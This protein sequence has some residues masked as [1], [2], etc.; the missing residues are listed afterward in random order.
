MNIRLVSD[1]HLEKTNQVVEKIEAAIPVLEKEVDTVLILAGDICSEKEFPIL[2][3]CIKGR[4]KKVIYIMGNH[5]FFNDHLNREENPFQ[6]KIKELNL[7]DDI[8][9]LEDEH[10][11]IDGYLFWGGT[12]WLNYNNGDKAVL[13]NAEFHNS[14]FKAIRKLSNGH[15]TKI[16]PRDIIKLHNESFINLSGFL[17]ANKDRMDKVI[18]VSHHAPS[19]CMSNIKS[20]MYSETS[21][22]SFCNKFDD[23]IQEHQ[24]KMWVS[25]HT[26]FCHDVVLGSTRLIANCSSILGNELNGFNPNFIIELD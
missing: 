22:H 19:H 1:L 21:S 3:D 12:M 25:G 15:S 8:V 14:D 24:P 23:F 20:R 11:D 26:H 13:F 4:F 5:E 10:I 6:N 17:N 16:F 9:V 7:Q 2:L 18:V